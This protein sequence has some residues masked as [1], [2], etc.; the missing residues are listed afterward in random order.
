M[1]R[2]AGSSPVNPQDLNRSADALNNPLPATD[3]TGHLPLLPVLLIG[4][5]ALLKA[6][7]DGWTAWDAVQATR[8]LADPEAPAEEKRAATVN[9]ALTAALEAAEPDD[10]LPVGLPLDDL[11]R[12]GIIGGSKGAGSS[13][14]RPSTLTPG[15]YAGDSIPARGPG[16]DF[17]REER[18]AI[19]EIG[20][21]TGCHTCGATD[22][23]T[24]D[25][26]FIPDHQPPNALSPPGAPQWLYPHCLAC[27]R[28][29]G[30]E[31]R[32]IQRRGTG[33]IQPQ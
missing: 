32:N 11:L 31:I 19:N 5:L 21:M 9:L 29:Q 14:T 28:R 20:R 26:N 12:V 23:G 30:G 7:D 13:R 22:P 27:S 4:G 15:P 6:I 25:G 1:W 16:R 3:P 2:S 33:A 24:I 10:L 8:T 18:D 17:T